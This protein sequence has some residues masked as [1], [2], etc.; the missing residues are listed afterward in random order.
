MQQSLRDDPRV[1]RALQIRDDGLARTALELLGGVRQGAAEEVV[2]SPAHR[3]ARLVR[4]A[5]VVPL[6]V[7][8]A[9]G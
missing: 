1:P 2:D 6:P 7:L 3:P 8:A 9:P 4:R 5:V